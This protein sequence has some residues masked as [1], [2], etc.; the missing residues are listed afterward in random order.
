M[1]LYY[2]HT[3]GEYY[4]ND[5]PLKIVETSVYK[6]GGHSSG[7]VITFAE[8]M[9]NRSMDK[10]VYIEGNT[11]I[12]DL[13]IIAHEMSHQW[14]GTGVNIDDDECF[15]SEGFA[16]YS[17]YK[18]VLNEFENS[19]FEPYTDIILYS[20]K[21]KADNLDKSYYLKSAQNLEKLN[22][23]YKENYKAEMS[24]IKRYDKMPLMLM[25]IEESKGEKKFLKNL[26][27]IYRD[28]KYG[29][30]TYDEFI[31]QADVSKEEFPNG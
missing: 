28:N 1:F 6:S 25:N 29:S 26:S 15:S 30:L 27:K 10:S 16:E 20:W 23:S 2:S 13:N 31:K 17:S 19:I 21:Q 14:W 22:K 5:Y 9:V 24:S 12:H 8:Y 7:N 18:F 11:L 3:F 4:T